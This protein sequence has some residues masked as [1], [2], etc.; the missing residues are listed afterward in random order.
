MAEDSV[1]IHELKE[2][3]KQ[4]E[5]L[6][7][8]IMQLEAEVAKEKH[9]RKEMKE[10]KLPVRNASTQPNNPEGKVEGARKQNPSQDQISNVTVPPMG[11]ELPFYRISPPMPVFISLARGLTILSTDGDFS[12]HVGGRLFADSG[13]STETAPKFLG[14]SSL[15]AQP[16]SG[17]YDQVGIRYARLQVLGSAY[18]IWDYKFQYYFAGA[19]NGLVV[20][21]LRDAYVMLRYPDPFAFQVGNF[22]EPFSLER[23]QSSNFRDFIEHGLP[24]DLLASSRHLGLAATVG[25]LAPGIGVPNW[26]MRGGTFSRSLEDGSP[27]STG[28]PA[29]G[30]SGF[31]NP[32]A[33]GKQ[34]WEATGRLTYAPILTADDLLNAGGSLRYQRPNDATAASDDTVLQ[35]GS[36]LRTEENILNM[37]LLGTQPL[38]CASASAQIAGE[39]P[40]VPMMMRQTP[41]GSLPLGA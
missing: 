25:G 21:G 27:N 35:L 29:A 5:P 15:P 12:F 18:R 38:T 22:F 40:S 9:E 4:L 13:F 8:R 20:G 41:A 6:K 19:A 23:T 36:T 11:S 32:V 30:S 3:V 37:N 7:A 24:S 14:T 33:G 31:L 34:Y 2:A 16:A 1:E 28:A 17:Y 10:L 39:N 26:Q